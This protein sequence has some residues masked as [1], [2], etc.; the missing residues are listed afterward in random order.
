MVA[1]SG[2]QIGLPRLSFTS[3]SGLCCIAG[4]M[5]ALT[6]VCRLTAQQMAMR[7]SM[8]EQKSQKSAYT[9]CGHFTRVEFAA[10]MPR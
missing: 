9:L 7:G 2:I 3:C 10:L 1:L 5:A 4:K 8:Q 6:S